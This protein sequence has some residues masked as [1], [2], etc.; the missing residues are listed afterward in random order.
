MYRKMWDYGFIQQVCEQDLQNEENVPRPKVHYPTFPCPYPCGPRASP[1]NFCT[2]R[3]CTVISREQSS[4]FSTLLWEQECR[5]I[6]PLR[7]SLL[8]FPVVDLMADVDTYLGGTWV[9]SYWIVKSVRWLVAYLTFC[10]RGS[11]YKKPTM[12]IHVNEANVE[13]TAVFQGL[14]VI[15]VSREEV[16]L[17]RLLRFIVSLMSQP[18]ALSSNFLTG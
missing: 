3:V 2:Q 14:P 17:M 10:E 15:V 18:P 4:L 6:R 8:L 16:L 7:L 11:S 5:S 12:A 13:M 1:L 9:Y